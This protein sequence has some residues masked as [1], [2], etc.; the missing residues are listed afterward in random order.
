MRFLHWDELWHCH[1]R[2][3]CKVNTVT[4][5]LHT[6]GKAEKLLVLC[7]RGHSLIFCRALCYFDCQVQ[8]ILFVLLKQYGAAKYLPS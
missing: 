8:V 1:N 5:F 7:D 4:L 3:A 2:I 6:L